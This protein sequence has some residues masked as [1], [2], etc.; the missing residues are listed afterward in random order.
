VDIDSAALDQATALQ[1]STPGRTPDDRTGPA[2]REPARGHREASAPLDRSVPA[3]LIR[4]DWNPAH[5]A[6]LGVIRSLGRAGVPVYAVLEK[7]GVP[8]GRSRYLTG[9]YPWL[10]P[11]SGPEELIGQLGELAARVGGRPVLF[12][13]DDAGALLLARYGALLDPVARFPGATG[14]VPARVADKE[15]LAQL[16]QEAGVGHPDTRVP[17]TPAELD[18]AVAE[19]GLPLIAKWSQPW[20]LKRGSGLRSTSVVTRAADAE[21]L[22]AQRAAA[23]CALLLQR[24]IPSTPGGDRFFHGY[25]APAAEPGGRAECRFGAAG[26]KDLAWPRSAGLTARGTWLPDPVI[27]A[28]AHRVVQ[29]AGF[30]GIV[31]LDFRFDPDTGQY[32]LL[33]FNPRLGAQFRLFTDP[34]GLDLARAAHLDLSGRAVP[35]LLPRPGRRLSV[36]TY[37]PLGALRPVP[38]A[39]RAWFAHDDLAPFPAAVFGG[40]ARLLN[41]IRPGTRPAIQEGNAQ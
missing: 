29:A 7:P 19:L 40:G 24:Q 28:A 1:Q 13:M 37:D 32:A 21:H 4:L 15:Q 2:R 22:F 34:T 20:Q 18:A 12:P 31:D 17:T 30:T 33:D 3:L 5:H 6:T 9:A 16:C 10:R 39:E 11:A 14:P 35:G 25:F 41:R 26:R 36:E 27:E 8:A 23:G 38:G